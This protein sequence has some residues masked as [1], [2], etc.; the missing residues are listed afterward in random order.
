[1]QY[2]DKFINIYDIKVIF[3]GNL[4]EEFKIFLVLSR[5]KY[6]YNSS[7]LRVLSVIEFS[8]YYSK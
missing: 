7:A 8:D 5:I 4:E 6:I 3:Y 2:W 1:M